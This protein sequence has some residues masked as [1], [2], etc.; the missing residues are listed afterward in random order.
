[1]SIS[2]C[3]SDATRA[4]T[5]SDSSRIEQHRTGEKSDVYISFFTARHYDDT[6]CAVVVCPSVRP[7]QA[8]IV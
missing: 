7:P 4:S 8:G 3:L 6:V 2:V 1:M 5:K